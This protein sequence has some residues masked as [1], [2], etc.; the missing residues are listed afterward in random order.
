MPET[1]WTLNVELL[2]RTLIGGEQ[3]KG[4]ALLASRKENGTKVYRRPTAEEQAEYAMD[5][6]W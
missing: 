3:I 6:A 2:D 1:K 5:E 4:P